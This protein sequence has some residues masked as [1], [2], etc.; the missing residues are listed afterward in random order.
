MSAARSCAGVSGLR[1]S[2]QVFS[3]KK[4]APKKA[5]PKSAPEDIG[6]LGRNDW[7]VRIR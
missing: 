1:R 2:L 5:K 3:N 6:F 7:E 4:K